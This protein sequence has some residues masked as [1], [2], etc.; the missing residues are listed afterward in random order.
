M[1]QLAFGALPLI[2]ANVYA[3][4]A[5]IQLAAPVAILYSG[6]VWRCAAAMR[7]TAVDES[8]VDRVLALLI[9]FLS[10]VTHAGW[11]AGST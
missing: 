6:W 4:L 8:A 3:D 10:V 2:S 1:L 7:T 9:L 11:L 5:A